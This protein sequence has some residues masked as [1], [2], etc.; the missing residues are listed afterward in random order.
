MKNHLVVV[1]AYDQL[2]TFEFG[3]AVELFAL[4]RQELEV[5][6]YNFAVCT[7][8]KG[9]IRAAGGIVV[10]APYS[11]SLLDQA[12]TIVIPG[13]RDPDELPPRALLKKLRDAYHRGARLCSI[14]SGSP[15]AHREAETAKAHRG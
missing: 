6:W 7:A 15:T 11:L 3:C 8:E 5:D 13:W 4:Q 9:K 14:C 1:L 12:D 2:C 10:E